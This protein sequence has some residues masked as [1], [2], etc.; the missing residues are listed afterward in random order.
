MRRADK[1]CKCAVN[2]V[3]QLLQE[4]NLKDFK[5]EDLGVIVAT[6]FGPHKTTFSFLDD[7]LDYG[8]L[9]VSPTRFSHSVHNAAASYIAKQVGARGPVT[10]VTNFKNPFEHAQRLANS[11]INESRADI[12]LVGLI[13]ELSEPMSFISKNIKDDIFKEYKDIAYFELIKRSEK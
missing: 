10:T 12:V 3:K 4:H 11:W 7:I 9:E 13:D 8:D 1:F 6:R 2:S 5:P